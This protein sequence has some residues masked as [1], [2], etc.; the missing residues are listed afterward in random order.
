M[1]KFIPLIALILVLILALPV[2]AYTYIASFSVVESS[3]STYSMLSS[4]VAANSTYLVNNSYILPSGLDVLIT[5]SA[6]TAL[7]TMVVDNMTMFATPLNALET[8][9]LKYTVGNTPASGFN[10]IPGYNGY[11]TV[12]DNTTLEPG[13]NSEISITGYIDTTKIGQDLFRKPG[14]LSCNITGSSN[15]TASVIVAGS[16]T[17]TTIN[18]IPSAPGD[19]TTIEANTGG[20]NWSCIDDPVAS[21]DD[22]TTYVRTRSAIQQLDV[23]NL[24]DSGLTGFPAITSVAVYFRT[25]NAATVGRAQPLLR[26]SGVETLGTEI[27]PAGGWTTYSEILTRPGGGSWAISDLDNLQAGVGLRATDDTQY[28]YCTQVYAVINYTP[29]NIELTATGVGAGHK[30]VTITLD[31]AAGGSLYLT[32]AGVTTGVGLNGVSAIDTSSNW[33]FMSPATP[34]LDSITVTVDGT[35]RAYYLPQTI[36]TGTNLPD[37]AL[38]D[39]TSNNGTFTWGTNPAG[40]ITSPLGSLVYYAQLYPAPPSLSSTETDIA[41]STGKHGSSYSM[42]G[43]N[44]ALASNFLHPVVSM[45][46]TLTTF[47]EPQIWVGGGT[48]FLIIF[49]MLAWGTEY[50]I[51]NK[52]TGQ[53]ENIVATGA[54]HI[55]LVGIAGMIGTYFLYK[56]GIYPWW[57]LIIMG[58][59]CLWS[60]IS[61]RAPSV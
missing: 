15:I 56:Y 47:S 39:G 26:L 59:V 5:D 11:I 12:A 52:A 10:I 25:Y 34:Y 57:T 58:S 54:R 18:L 41:P 44:P 27:N 23:Y 35:L 46:A 53:V 1:R 9:N 17:P 33:T 8:K 48:I 50:T 37:R 60:L 40:V 51:I 55:G 49:M 61:E 21:P 36:I 28:V 29:M 42:P 30:N 45:F 4:A 31:P 3:G 2:L 22:A 20:T 24:A 6:G 14:E 38:G 43:S 32:V 19:Y 13:N 16:G 7:P